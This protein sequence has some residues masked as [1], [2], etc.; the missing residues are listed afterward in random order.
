M[1]ASPRARPFRPS[2][3]KNRLSPR[4]QASQ[5]QPELSPT[6]VSPSVNRVQPPPLLP[7]LLLLPTRRRRCRCCH[8]GRRCRHRRRPAAAAATAA[9]HRRRRCCHRRCRWLPPPLPLLP[10]PTVAAAA[11]PIAAAASAAQARSPTAKN[12]LHRKSRGLR[13]SWNHTAELSYDYY[14]FGSTCC[15]LTGGSLRNACHKM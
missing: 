12:P 11:A 14:L 7:P 5:N 6:S 4:T 1:V 2:S 10:F 8:R 15:F 13:D 3:Q 9:A